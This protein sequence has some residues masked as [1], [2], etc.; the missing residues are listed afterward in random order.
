M[1]ARGERAGDRTASEML[2]FHG[3]RVLL[4]PNLPESIGFDVSLMPMAVRFLDVGY[5]KF[6][7][8]IFSTIK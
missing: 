1:F 8:G 2:S 4:H 5:I 6:R 7:F 3:N